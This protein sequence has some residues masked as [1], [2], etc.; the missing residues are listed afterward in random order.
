MACAVSSGV[1][2]F[3]NSASQDPLG[4]S[5]A[6][7]HKGDRRRPRLWRSDDSRRSARYGANSKGGVGAQVK[8]VSTERFGPAAAYTGFTQRR[9][10]RKGEQSDSVLREILFTWLV[11]AAIGAFNKNLSGPDHFFLFLPLYP[12][13][14]VAHPLNTKALQDARIGLR[15]E[16]D[17]AMSKQTNWKSL[18]DLIRTVLM[19]LLPLGVAPDNAGERRT[20]FAPSGGGGRSRHCLHRGYLA[21]SGGKGSLQRRL[22]HIGRWIL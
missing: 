21:P 20:A 7:L 4:E 14:R 11:P 10:A 13:K 15:A 8:L 2:T 17:Q 5:A 18:K 16:E 12:C 3:C 6:A 22:F 19:L 9:K 1:C